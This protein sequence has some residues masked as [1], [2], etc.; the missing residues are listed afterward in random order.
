[1][2]E[3]GRSRRSVAGWRY[4]ARRDL[5]ISECG[6]V[7]SV[8]VFNRRYKIRPATQRGSHGEVIIRDTK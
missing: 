4:D 5:M 7:M 6:E 3:E 8:E 1:M 2:S